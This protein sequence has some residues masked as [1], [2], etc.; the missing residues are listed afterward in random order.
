MRRIRAIKKVPAKERRRRQALFQEHSVTS[1]R[2]DNIIVSGE[3]SISSRNPNNTNPLPPLEESWSSRVLDHADNHMFWYQSHRPN[4]APSSATTSETSVV[5]TCSTIPSDSHQ[6]DKEPDYHGSTVES[7]T[8]CGKELEAATFLNSEFCALLNKGRFLDE[9][10]DDVSLL[11]VASS[12][13]LLD[14]FMPFFP[15]SPEED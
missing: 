4:H 7:S 15:I 14:E 3:S 2:Q 13:S 12:L 5:T 1:S 6:E 9:Q 10:Q 11:S 8:I